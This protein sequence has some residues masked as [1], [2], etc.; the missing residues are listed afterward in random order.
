MGGLL[1]DT[2]G[3]SRAVVLAL[4]QVGQRHGS[5]D[6]PPVCLISAL[7]LLLLHNPNATTAPDGD[8]HSEGKRREELLKPSTLRST[9]LLLD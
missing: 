9:M 1:N 2:A 7:H 3:G 6:L 8:E 4:R 5:I